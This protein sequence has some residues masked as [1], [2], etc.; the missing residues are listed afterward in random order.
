MGG[1]KTFL[2]LMLAFSASILLFVSFAGAE[3]LCSY[4]GPSEP[5]DNLTV[6]NFVIEGPAEPRVGDQIRVTFRLKNTGAQPINLT[7]R[8]MFGMA[9]IRHAENR[10]FGNSF[11]NQTL[12]PN[13]YKDFD[14]NITID[15]DG[16]WQVWPSYEIWLRTYSKPLEHYVYLK[17]EG[18]SLWHA[19][20]LAACPDH[21]ESGTR[22]HYTALNQDGTCTYHQETCALGCDEQ[23]KDCSN[24][25]RIAITEGPTIKLEEES[26]APRGT[27]RWKTNIEGSGVVF[28]REFGSPEWKNVSTLYYENTSRP[29]LYL[30]GLE[31]NRTY[32]Y[33]VKSCGPDD[34]IESAP[35]EFTTINYLRVQ[36]VSVSAAQRLATI[37]WTARCYEPDGLPSEWNRVSTNYT[38]YVVL[39]SYANFA[40][41]PWSNVSNSTY[42]TTHK[43]NLSGMLD[44]GKNYTFF[45]RACNA[46]G[47]C[48]DSDR[49]AFETKERPFP[50]IFDLRTEPAHTSVNIYWNT[51]QLVNTTVYLIKQQSPPPNL[52]SWRKTF[53]PSDRTDHSASFAALESGTLYLFVIEHCGGGRCNKTSYN[54]FETI[55][56][57]D[58][59][60]NG[61]EYGV[62]CGGPCEAKCLN[63]TWCGRSITPVYLQ[64]PPEE[65]I[66]IVFVASNTS[67]DRLNSVKVPK[68]TY[69]YYKNEFIAAV[70]DL[71]QNWYLKLDTLVSEPI[72]SDF[73]QRFNFYYYWDSSKFGDAFEGCSGTLPE[74]FW[75]DARFA[76][77]GGILY[78]AHYVGG[79]TEAGGCAN[80]FGPP[81]QFKGPGF[82][83]YVTIHE[84][85]HAVFALVDEYCGE[86]AYFQ[87]DPL[88][89]VW[90]SLENCTGDVASTMKQDP[91][92]CR[93]ITYDDPNTAGV[94]CTRDWWR[95]NPNDE[96]MD[97]AC[98]RFGPM[99]VRHINY[100]FESRDKWRR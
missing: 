8:G 97:C 33:Y 50:E 77:V 12:S 55:G 81:S 47:V 24:V 83:G 71:V 74:G 99:C 91:S 6:S 64:G 37:R 25:S 11:A 89:N 72:S 58:G 68:N 49:Y 95:W 18:P 26:C 92:G 39:S 54:A 88:A 62:D 35:Q 9:K 93:Q 94:D 17:K 90:G 59:I 23:G 84:S 13:G 45:I 34:C 52:T 14:R 44:D 75:N 29:S 5:S 100:M 28:Y 85:G 86:T 36:D 42:N 82:N 67:W 66:D 1:S 38:L 32:Y 4:T 98:G 73:R 69:S 51:F 40:S 15:E 27:A 87:N 76:D 70:N 79:F 41:P 53:D 65:K 31:P 61:G 16:S 10:E 3:I 30:Y 43:A 22:Y 48:T 56:C 63:C 78:P 2:P 80:A 46:G 96:I 7:D 20:Q 21:C 19:C 57:F 60:L